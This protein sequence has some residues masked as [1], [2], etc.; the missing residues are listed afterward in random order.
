MNQETIKLINE[1][2][3]N[4]ATKKKKHERC[5]ELGTKIHI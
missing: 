4:V 5:V 1:E 2:V 3:A